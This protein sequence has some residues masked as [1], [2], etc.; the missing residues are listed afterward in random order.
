MGFAL[1]LD[2]RCLQLLQRSLDVVGKL[3]FLLLDVLN[4]FLDRENNQSVVFTQSSSSYCLHFGQP[5]FP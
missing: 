3:T 2:L 4:Q 5:A 1:L